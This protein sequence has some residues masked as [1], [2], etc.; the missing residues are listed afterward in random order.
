LLA[1]ETVNLDQ[2]T[3]RKRTR[4]DDISCEL[5]FNVKQNEGY[6]D[7]DSLK[8]IAS[9]LN[10]KDSFV[11]EADIV[12]S[13]QKSDCNTK[14]TK[15]AVIEVLRRVY[16]IMRTLAWVDSIEFRHK[17]RIPIICVNHTNGISCDISVVS[18]M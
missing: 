4:T 5:D 18:C 7:R 14:R 12:Q 3:S 11:R 16:A 13:K 6:R 9:T 17:A 1:A 15:T 10:V 8:G 2:H